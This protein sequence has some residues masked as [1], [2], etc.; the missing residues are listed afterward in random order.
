MPVELGE[1]GP[2][3]PGDVVMVS[4]AMWDK[5]TKRPFRWRFFLVVTKQKRWT[6]HGYVV[7]NDKLKDKEIAVSLHDEKNEV[8]F[9]PMEEWP[10]G[11]HAFRMSM[12][13][14]GLIEDV[15]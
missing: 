15:V 7:G 8:Q 3:V 2:V 1:H 13:L 9:L 5:K 4:R 6:I 12:V 14:R 11:V 10:D